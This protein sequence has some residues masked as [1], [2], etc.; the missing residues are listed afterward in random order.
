MTWPSIG[1]YQLTTKRVILIAAI[2]LDAIL[3]ATGKGGELLAVVL[4]IWGS[5]ILFRHLRSRMLW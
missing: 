5:W 4:A 2:V 1:K 3:L